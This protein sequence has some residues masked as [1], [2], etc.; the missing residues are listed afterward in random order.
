MSLITNIFNPEGAKVVCNIP[1]LEPS[2]QHDKLVWHFINH[3]MYTVKRGY[4]VSFKTSE[5]QRDG[6]SSP[7]PSIMQGLWRKSWELN[8]MGKV[9][10]FV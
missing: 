7:L 10:H 8:I 6:V 1:I 5:A 3:E 4:R 2:R 9:K